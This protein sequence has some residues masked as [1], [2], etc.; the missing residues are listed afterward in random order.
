MYKC[1]AAKQQQWVYVHLAGSG[2][3]DVNGRRN[4]V[5][6]VAWRGGIGDGGGNAP[7]PS[8]LWRPRSTTGHSGVAWRGGIGDG[9]GNAPGPPALWRPRSTTRRPQD[10]LE[11]SVWAR[12]PRPTAK[13]DG[14]YVDSPVPTSVLFSPTFS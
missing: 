6:T 4:P 10:L 8:A 13:Q 1:R 5:D 3:A 9:G 11:R 14:R 2:P 7:G 12:A